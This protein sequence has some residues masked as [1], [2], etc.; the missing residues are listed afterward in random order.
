MTRFYIELKSG[1]KTDK[2]EL[3]Q[4]F[5]MQRAREI[6]APFDVRGSTSSGSAGIRLA[7]GWRAGSPTPTS[8]PSWPATASHTHS[9]QGRPPGHEHVDARRLE[10]GVEAQLGRAGVGAAGAAG[11]LR[12]GA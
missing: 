1:P 7:S 4:E 5:V 2:R 8:R 6:M 12:T 10:P 3:G 9:P 11:E